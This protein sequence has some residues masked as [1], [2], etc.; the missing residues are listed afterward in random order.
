[1]TL[2]LFQAHGV[3]RT[4]E[5]DVVSHLMMDILRREHISRKTDL[6]RLTHLLKA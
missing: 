5:V 2:P 6:V 1:M 3:S 4:T